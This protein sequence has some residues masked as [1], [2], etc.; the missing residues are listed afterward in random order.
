MKITAYVPQPDSYTCQSAC[1]AKM[2]GLEKEDVQ[3]I[4]K[5]LLAL[6]N[7]GDPYIMGAMLVGSVK[8]YA[9]NEAASVTQMRDWL[10]AGYQLITHGWFTN[11][12]HVICLVGTY[13]KGFIADD[14][15]G[16]F[17]APRWAYSD[18]WNGDDLKYSNRLIYA[19][20]VASYSCDEASRIYSN[21]ALDSSL[22]N[23]WVH[24]IKN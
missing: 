15:W 12:G 3:R 24:R 23:A 20:C 5:N 11:P 21:G 17:D 7:P 6:G 18:N 9:F 8:E 1:V 22:K 14:P 10:K 19:S 16:E 2:M 13:D 4:R